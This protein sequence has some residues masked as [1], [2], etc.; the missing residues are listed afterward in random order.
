[1]IAVPGRGGFD[2]AKGSE[3]GRGVGDSV[4]SRANAAPDLLRVVSDGTR[5]ARSAVA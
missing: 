5:F 1:M 4:T 3:H 2:T